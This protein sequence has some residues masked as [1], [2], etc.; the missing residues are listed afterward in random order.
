MDITNQN[1]GER[2]LWLFGVAF[3]ASVMTGVIPAMRKFM[4]SSSGRKVPPSERPWEPSGDP[5]S[6]HEL[7]VR[8]TGFEPDFGSP[9]GA[10]NARVVVICSPLQLNRLPIG[11]R[12]R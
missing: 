8:H 12:T 9:L 4:E 3:M 6:A 7:P 2:G 1:V 11:V 10:S 5:S